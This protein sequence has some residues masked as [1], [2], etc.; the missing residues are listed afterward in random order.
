MATRRTGADDRGH[1]DRLGLP[2]L[3]QPPAERAD[4]ARSRRALLAAARAMV[5][6]CGG[7][8][9]ALS[10]SELACRA[11]VGVGTIYRRF[12]DRS[13]LALALLDNEEKRFQWAYIFGP[14]P[15]GPEAPPLVRLRAFMHAY[16]DRLEV[17]ADLHTVSELA[18]PTSRYRSAP[19]RTHH[20]HLVMLIRAA[21]L[22][23]DPGYLADTL[24]ALLSGGRYIH[25]RRERE[26]APAEIKAAMDQLLDRLLEP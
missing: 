18:S 19:Y 8:L 4:A 22:D 24:L 12:G 17:E 6:E 10:M 9:G 21:E 7:G 3:G 13:G 25:H 2:V 26:M 14:P 15:M 20:T 16:L 1:P 5:S 11:G 23:V